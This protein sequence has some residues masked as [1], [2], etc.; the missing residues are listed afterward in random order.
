MIVDY[1]DVVVAVAEQ[2]PGIV[3]GIIF[4]KRKPILVLY[5]A[6]LDVRRECATFE[7]AKLFLRKRVE[8]LPVVK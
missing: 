3:I 7:E 5:G 2:P 8:K 6:L 1:E 4:T